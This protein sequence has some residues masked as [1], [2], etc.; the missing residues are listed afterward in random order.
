MPTQLH[1]ASRIDRFILL[2]CP[3]IKLHGCIHVLFNKKGLHFKQNK[4]Y[5]DLH[6]HVHTLWFIHVHVS[7]QKINRV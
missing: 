5:C 3:Q 7:R 4:N 1:A 6:V 2:S